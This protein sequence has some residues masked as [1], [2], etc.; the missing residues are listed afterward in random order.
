MPD[1]AVTLSKSDFGIFLELARCG[2]SVHLGAFDSVGYAYMGR[3]ALAQFFGPT[4]REGMP[5]GSGS[6]RVA[7]AQAFVDAETFK[8]VLNTLA[9]AAN[10]LGLPEDA[11]A[12][13]FLRAVQTLRSAAKAEG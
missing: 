1:E 13:D 5:P 3:S 8:F 7:G 2:A 11:K 10:V 9:A 4:R 6:V 12:E